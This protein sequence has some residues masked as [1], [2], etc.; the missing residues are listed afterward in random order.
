MPSFGSG[1]ATT[2]SM[3]ALQVRKG[4]L[5]GRS[6]LQREGEVGELGSLGPEAGDGTLTVPLGNTP[7]VTVL[8]NT[9]SPSQAL[10]ALLIDASTTRPIF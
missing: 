10:P 5:Q 9:R 3:L 4:H 1:P 2:R 6:L 7:C 8:L